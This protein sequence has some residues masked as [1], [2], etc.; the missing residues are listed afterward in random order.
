MATN[1]KRKTRA[2]FP[3]SANSRNKISLISRALSIPK[4]VTTSTALKPAATHPFLAVAAITTSK[5]DQPQ[6]RLLLVPLVSKPKP[7]AK[8]FAQIAKVNIFSSKFAFVSSYKDFLYLLQ[9]KKAFPNLSQATII[10]IYQTSLDVVRAS[11]VIL[12]S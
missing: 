6:N 4:T 5:P 10:S 8:L 11:P 9:L 1:K 2:S 3:P 7:K 12:L